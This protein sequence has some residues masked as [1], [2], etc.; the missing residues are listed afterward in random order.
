MQKSWWALFAALVLLLSLALIKEAAAPFA[1]VGL[2]LA[3]VLLI[4]AWRA[5]AWRAISWNLAVLCLVLGL[6][7][8][9]MYRLSASRAVPTDVTV[10]NEGE[11]LRAVR[12]DV[13]GY[14]PIKNRT[15]SWKRRVGGESVFD[16]TYTIDR[17]GLRVAPPFTGTPPGECV[18]FFG[19]SFTFGAGVNDSETLPYQT[20]VKTD[21]R[22]RVYNF[23]YLGYGPHQMLAALENGLTSFPECKP[24]YAIYQGITSHVERVVAPR[25]WDQHG[26]K[27]VLE[28]EK[29]VALGPFDE[30]QAHWLIKVRESVDAI[31]RRSY[32]FDRFW[33]LFESRSKQDIELAA[34]VI[35]AAAMEFEGRYPGAEFHIV[36]WDRPGADVEALLSHLRKYGLNLHLASTILP[37]MSAAPHRFR[38]PGD[39]HPNARAHERI[40]DYL[41][42]NVLAD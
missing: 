29:V 17:W 33:E 27:Y 41:A 1:W 18:F 37:E 32:V 21:G 30:Y 5:P 16:I 22:Y 36:F 31:A 8:I 11:S 9:Y 40:A 35:A 6:A 15:V 25:S 10:D 19:G 20:G 13:L 38:I 2:L 34:A 23:G 26:P 39:L 28:G 4:A 42:K 7:E 3:A 14:R 24:R 12:D